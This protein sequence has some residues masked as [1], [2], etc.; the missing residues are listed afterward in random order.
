MLTLSQFPDFL[1]SRVY[2]LYL[3]YKNKKAINDLH[4]T[5]LMIDYMLN[6]E[7]SENFVAIMESC[8]MQE[9]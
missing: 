1:L 8:L 2:N 6:H 9:K 7:F 3:K 5:Q 4:L